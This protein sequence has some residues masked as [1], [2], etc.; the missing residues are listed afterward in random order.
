MKLTAEMDKKVSDVAAEFQRVSHKQMTETS[1]RTLRENQ[2]I[3]AQMQKV[4]ATTME[5]LEENQKLLEENKV[6]KQQNALLSSAETEWATRTNENKKVIH[7]LRSDLR[8]HQEKLQKQEAELLN[9]KQ[10]PSVVTS[11]HA[12]DT[13]SPGAPLMSVTEEASE[14][15]T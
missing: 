11:Y 4:S 15:A 6:L 9:T 14:T 13:S 10:Q 8:I 3:T 7:E 1:K 5:L 12:P 2:S